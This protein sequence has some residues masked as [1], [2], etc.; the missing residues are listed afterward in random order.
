MRVVIDVRRTGRTGY[1]IAEALR[2]DYDIHLELATHAPWSWCSGVGQPIE[3]LEHFA[4]DLAESVARTG[5]PGPRRR[6][7]AR[8][9]P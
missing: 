3:P 4:R 2:T 1:E 7:R 5:R 6:S 9:P 8:R